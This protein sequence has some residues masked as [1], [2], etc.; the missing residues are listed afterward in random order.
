MF[1]L[2][3]L[4]QVA[5]SLLKLSLASRE[6]KIHL[7]PDALSDAQRERLLRHREELADLAAGERGA[8]RFIG[9]GGRQVTLPLAP[10]YLRVL[11][12]ALSG[13]AEGRTV[14]VAPAGEELTTSQAAE[15]LGVSRPHLRKLLKEQEIP[16]HKVGTHHRVQRSDVLAYKER[17][18]ARAEDAMQALADQ[19]Q[20][21]GMGY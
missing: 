3:H 18:R 16:Y 17:Q 19:A 11:A 7:R 21:L 9:E 12:E 20:E 14:S 13:V 2:L 15:L 4:V 8:V 5:S 1:Y 10:D 6:I